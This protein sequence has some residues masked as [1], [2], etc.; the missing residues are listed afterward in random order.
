MEAIV[1]LRKQQVVTDVRLDMPIEENLS[2]FY[3]ERMLEEG[4]DYSISENTLILN[5]NFLLSLPSHPLGEVAVLHCNFSDGTA[6]TIRINQLD[7]LPIKAEASSTKRKAA[8]V[9]IGGAGVLA[10]AAI[11]KFLMSRRKQ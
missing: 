11:A 1:N 7:A 6:W 4:L 8:K 5:A 2:V 3:G 10:I 9:A